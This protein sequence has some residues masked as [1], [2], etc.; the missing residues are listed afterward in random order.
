MNKYIDFE[1]F[2]KDVENALQNVAKDYGLCIG[3]GNIRYD[4]T[5]F[6][7]QLKCE[8]ADVDV[9]K[10]RFDAD[11]QYMKYAGFEADDYRR[12]V[13]IDGKEFVI[14]G[15][16]P[17]NKYDVCLERKD[18]KQYAYTSRAVLLALGRKTA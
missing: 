16:K 13:T 5:S 18:G 12:E 2:R 10:I 8:R 3:T 9:S 1:A 17:G 7:M 15:F 4:A 14:T 6:T 11:L